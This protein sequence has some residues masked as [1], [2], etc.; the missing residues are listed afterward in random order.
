MSRPVQPKGDVWALT[1][2]KALLWRR[3]EVLA[4]FEAETVREAYA[5]VVV[6]G[7]VMSAGER[8]VVEDATAAMLA[9]GTQDLTSA[10]LAA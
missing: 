4:D 9:A 2:A 3:D 8:Q 6:G 5:R 10:G 1:R 7:G